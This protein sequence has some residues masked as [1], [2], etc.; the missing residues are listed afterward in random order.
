M[1]LVESGYDSPPSLWRNPS[2]LIL[3]ATSIL[4]GLGQ[5]IYSL[6][7]PLLV[8]ELTESS[9]WMGWMRA[10]EFLPNLVLALFIG[11]WVDRFNRKRWAMH[12]L[13]GQTSLL[14]LAFVAIQWQVAPL[15]VLFPAAFC[16][17][18]CAYGYSNA[19]MGIMKVVLPH[20]HL[21]LATARISGVSNLFDTAGPAIS[22]ALLLLAALHWPLLWVGVT[23]LAAW[24]M[25][26]HL[27]WQQDEPPKHHPPVGRALSEGWH[28]LKQNRPLWLITWMVVVVNTTSGIF[29][30]Q[31]IFAAKSLYQ[32]NS[33]QIGI[34]ASLAG[35][36][37]L[38]GS[39]VAPYVRQALGLG[40]TLLF[41]VLLEA[42]CFTLP[43]IFDSVWGLYLGL[44]LSGCVSIVSSIC[45]WSFR[46]ESTSAELLGRVAGITGSLFKLGLP[47][48]LILSGYVVAWVGVMPLFLACAVLQG[49]AAVIMLTSEVA[50][51]A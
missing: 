18:A 35:L 38:V 19:K 3:M 12:M 9:A 13:L 36:G 10:V 21:N 30:I 26:R 31:V 41:S 27:P 47:F 46:Q 15:W 48:G 37:A 28:A 7:L 39:L 24:W 23:T 42:A 33:A 22:G 17:N 1:T 45:I 29:D 44:A 43:V 8:Y 11:V 6:A 16:I 34:M 25:F 14:V 40:R 49:L 51:V 32:L 20:R 2:F 5:K 50:R 4:L